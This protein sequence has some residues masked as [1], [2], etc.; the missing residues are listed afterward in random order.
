MTYNFIATSGK[1]RKTNNCGACGSADFSETPPAPS[2]NPYNTAADAE[3]NQPA[4]FS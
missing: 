3:K 1:P 2:K 4:A